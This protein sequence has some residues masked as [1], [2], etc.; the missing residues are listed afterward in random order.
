M[1][2]KV[3]VFCDKVIEAGWLLALIVIPLFFNLYS[4]RVFEPDKLTLLRSITVL[5]VAARLIRWAEEA[6]AKRAGR[7]ETSPSHG[8][9][10][11]LRTPLVVPTLLLAVVYLLA[12]ATS[13]VPRISLWG[14][15][16][17][18]Q[19]TYTTFSYVV[20]F[21]LMLENLRRQEQLRR[22][23]T[24]IV[25][26]SLPIS[27][28]GLL[29]H[30]QLDPLP[31]GGDVT[32]RVASNMGNAIFIGS[33]LIMVIPLTLART[34]Q[35]QS[36]IL[37]D[38][39]LKAKIGFG[40]FFW[41]ILLLQM[42]SWAALGFERG[43]ATGL[44][45][46][47][48]LALIAA[49]LRRPIARFV[50]LG[51]YGLILSTQTICLVFSQ[52]RGPLLGMIAALLFFCLL[53]AF[54]RRWRTTIVV[55]TGSA[56][57]LLLLLVLINLPN[58]PLAA[59]R[60][61]P[62]VGRLGKVFEIEGGTGKVRVLIWE[63]AVEMLKANPLRTLIGYGPESMYVAY[64]PFYP[65][66]LAHYEA[67]NASPDRSHNE[68]FDA[69]I[70]TGVLGLALYMLIFGGALYYGLKWLGLIPSRRR[71]HSF[72]IC[73]AA[74]ALLGIIVPLAVEGSLR[75][76]GVG[77]PIGFI[78]GVSVYMVLS[79]LMDTF[80]GTAKALGA[81]KPRLSGWSL[82]LTIALLSAIVAHFV[83]INFGIAIAATRT[84]FWA[85]LALLILLGQKLIS[86]D[87]PVESRRSSQ[88]TGETTSKGRRQG[89]RRKGKRRREADRHKANLV[90]QTAVRVESLR[91]QL[92]AIALVVS[93]V[94]ITM[95][96][97][98][99][100]NSQALKNPFAVIITSLTTMASARMP[101][102][103]SLGMTWFMLA[104]FVLSLLIA[105]PELA[106]GEDKERPTSW[107]LS[108]YGMFA[109]VAGGIGGLFM[110]L[111]AVNLRPGVRISELIYGY[112]AAIFVVWMILASTLYFGAPRPTRLTR[113]TM[114][115]GYLPLLVACVFL[116]DGA[117]IRI[118]KADTLYKQGLRYDQARNWD[119]AIH[120]YRQAVDAVPSEDYYS[121]FLGRALMEKAKTESDSNLRD[122]Y[123]NESLESLEQARQLNPLNTDHT[124]N[125]ARIHRTWA[126]SDPEGASRDEK[127]QQALDYY[128]QATKLS[129]HNAQLFNEWG[130]IYYLLG[131]FDKALEKLDESLIL[132]D[133]F[134]QTYLLMGEVYLARKDWRQMILVHE[135]ATALNPRLV[136]GWSS[137]GYA[138]SQLQE[139]DKAIEAN[140]RVVE[141]APD[142]YGTLKNIAIL[143]SETNQ[144]QK[145]LSYAKRAI[146]VAPEKDKP[147]LETFTKRLQAQLEKDKS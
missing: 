56:F 79:A 93:V 145:A 62:Y 65:P 86:V 3:S 140:L 31:W 81:E 78:G 40:L 77:L 133:R 131:E 138:Y 126:E 87:S 136:Q 36:S 105:I 117:N 118:I 22:L 61:I 101:E 125:L 33:Y 83:E 89:S 35:I 11:W 96:W 90:A 114:A 25:L 112:Y 135:Q 12:T 21:L 26:T 99:T 91:T 43:L 15:Y 63:G 5:M 42:W 27:L 110:L 19:G 106:E 46:I 24:A 128:E 10:Q 60:D 75:F 146:A 98:Y 108:F 69:L 44:L 85:Y 88:A 20:V 116:I 13:V 144:T 1:R 124:A 45:V 130:L 103:V 109:L 59:I 143:Y 92:I 70:T 100:T 76:A 38:Y 50:L 29:Q 74:G 113:G 7:D 4:S 80:K 132:D 134:T 37:K 137:I 119:Y 39:G 16:Q 55:F 14:S 102:R 127:L 120:F 139:F 30:Y 34:I 82:L 52:S 53:Y 32:F 6:S 54:C 17:R 122:A 104:V 94:L 123:F 95:A 18:L 48:M 141:I 73:S 47:M 64:N 68:T 121:L 71:E 8:T 115:I 9:A 72:Y 147:T 66:D 23:W 111:H 41:S 129:P 84:Y 2:T 49:Y 57:V 107:W 67:R 58:T 28:Y 51:G 142:D 97:D